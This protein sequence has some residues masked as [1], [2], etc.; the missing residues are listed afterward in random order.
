MKSY[1]N[2][3]SRVIYSFET[4]ISKKSFPEESIASSSL[5]IID[6]PS[7]NVYTKT[8]TGG[9]NNSPIIRVMTDREIEKYNKIIIQ[10]KDAILNFILLFIVMVYH[11]KLIPRD[12]IKY[13]F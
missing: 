12:Y 7:R 2:C 10:R 6:M 5:W 4:E 9:M 1:L 13:M 8:A 3:G 11:V